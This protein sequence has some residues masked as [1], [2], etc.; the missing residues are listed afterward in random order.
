VD[1]LLINTIQLRRSA[2]TEFSIESSSDDHGF[3]LRFARMI[4]LRPLGAGVSASE[5]E[6]ER[7]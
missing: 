4:C 7:G 5:R 6:L 2:T 3:R 1:D